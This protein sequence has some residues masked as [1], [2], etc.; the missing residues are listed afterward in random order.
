MIVQ[1]ILL[2]N[3]SYTH[4]NWLHKDICVGFSR[5]YYIIDGEAYYEEEGRKIR[6]KKGHL[7]LTPVKKP[8]TLSENREDK[9]LHTYA[10]ITTLPTV[11]S[12]IEI[13]V[14][15]G[16]PLA[17]GVA[18]W[19]KYTKQGDTELLL[20]VIQFILARVAHLTYNRGSTAARTKA[21]LDCL[22]DFVFDS[23]ALCRALGYTREHITRKFSEAYHMTP[24]QYFNRRRM[25]YALIALEGGSKIAPLAETLHFSTPYAFSK[26]FKGH[27]GLSPLKFRSTLSQVPQK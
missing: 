14:T 18:L 10:H 3:E 9:L 27:F 19:R 17:D 22:S 21:Y 11:K 20:S 1:N 12:L 26:A 23:D 16:T 24:K 5:L 7:Y 2:A 13:P 15:E 6:L 4:Q 8:F 25:E